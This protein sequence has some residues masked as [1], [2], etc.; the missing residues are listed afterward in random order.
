[1][2]KAVIKKVG[3]RMEAQNAK[4]DAGRVYTQEE[5]VALALDTSAVKFDASVEVHFRL[6]I[7]P[8]KGDQQIRGTVTLP[9][10]SGKTKRV[11]AFVDEGKEQEAKDAGAD[12]V[13]DIQMI[14][15]IAQK[16]NIDFDVAVST[17]TMMPKLGKIAQIL[18]PKGLMPNP[19]T[20]TV[21]K[22]IA[23]MIN[24]QKGGK[25]A[26]KNDATS[27]VHVA[28]GKVSF[29]ANKIAEHL[30]IIVDAIKRAKPA[31][32]KGIYVKSATITTSMG[33]GIRFSVE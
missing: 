33:P 19:K 32:A 14:A 1:M 30:T 7:D 18:G 4:L 21:G 17:P 28:I 2:A 8:K 23:K 13:G 9:H 25:I 31:T 26:F 27:N 16:K 12:I 24:E 22:D 3:K 20:D 6:G 11:I 5:V 10:G 15:E 29:G